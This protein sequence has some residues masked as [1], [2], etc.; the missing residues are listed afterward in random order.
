MSSKKFVLVFV[1]VLVAMLA[2]ACGPW[3]YN[4]AC[5]SK[6][7]DTTGCIPTG[8][9]ADAWLQQNGYV[10]PQVNVNVTVPTQPAPQINVQVPTQPA[11]TA[12]PTQPSVASSCRIIHDY[13]L[14]ESMDHLSTSGSH[15]HVEYWWNGQPERETFLPTAGVPGG[16]YNLTRSLKGHVWEYSDCSDSEVMAQINVHIPRRLAGGA[17]NA[18]YVAWQTTGLFQPAK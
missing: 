18:G 16:R 11:P 7:G 4:D 8:A 14:I 12:Q 10:R 5:V 3:V 13:D 1:L 9:Q 17:N 6:V 15:L 2:T